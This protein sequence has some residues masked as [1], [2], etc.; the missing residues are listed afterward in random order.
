MLAQSYQANQE[1]E[2]K[3]KDLKEYI[4]DGI[5]VTK[6]KTSGYDVF[7]VPTQHFHV[8]DI[9]E[10]TPIRFWHEREKQQNFEKLND[11]FTKQLSSSFLGE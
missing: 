5:T 2:K 4:R 10:L 8:K 11:K 3:M 6:C 1:S 9:E 7:T